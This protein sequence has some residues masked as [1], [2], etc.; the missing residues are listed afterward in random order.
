MQNRLQKNCVKLYFDG[1]YCTFYSILVILAAILKK[2][3]HAP[4]TSLR[5]WQQVESC[6][7]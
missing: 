2:R 3:P 4:K 1:K 6:S 7:L 5:F